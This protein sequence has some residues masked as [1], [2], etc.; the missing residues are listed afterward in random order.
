MLTIKIK[1][2]NAAFGDYKHSETAR[3]LHDLAAKIEFADYPETLR[4]ANGN[5]VGTVKVTD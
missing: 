4:D 5:K 1:R 3:I 2:E